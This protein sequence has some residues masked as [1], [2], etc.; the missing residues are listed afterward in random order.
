MQVRFKDE[1]SAKLRY[2]VLQ[3]PFMMRKELMSGIAQL[4]DFDEQLYKVRA[5][6]GLGLSAGW[7]VGGGSKERR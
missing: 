6:P 5:V 7:R 2:E 3:P 4:E 1:P